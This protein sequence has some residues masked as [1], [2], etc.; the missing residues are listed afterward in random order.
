[1]SSFDGVAARLKVW[2]ECVCG[3]GLGE[4]H[5][6]RSAKAALAAEY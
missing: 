3:G 6:W 1:M 4:G 2:E 5:C